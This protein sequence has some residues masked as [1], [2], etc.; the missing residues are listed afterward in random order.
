MAAFSTPFF[1]PPFF[2]PFEAL[3]SD[4]S[5]RFIF[6]RLIRRIA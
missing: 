4:F 5:A 2:A 6:A 1:A 3:E